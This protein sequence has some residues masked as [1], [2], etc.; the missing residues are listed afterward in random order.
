MPEMNRYG[1]ILRPLC[2]RDNHKDTKDTKAW[3]GYLSLWQPVKKKSK[4]WIADSFCTA[5]YLIHLFDFFFFS[6]GYRYA[7]YYF[8]AFVLFVSLW[9]K[10]PIQI[11]VCSLYIG[12]ITGDQPLECQEFSMG[13]NISNGRQS[14]HPRNK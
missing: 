9:F 13:K 2:L 8:Q 14:R 12:F 3:T 11:L 7:G 10:T 6:S 1:S 5:E 4:R